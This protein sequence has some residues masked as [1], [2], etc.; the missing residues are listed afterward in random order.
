MF[1]VL[2]NSYKRIISLIG[3][4]L[5]SV[6]SFAANGKGLPDMGAPTRGQDKS[7][8]GTIQNYSYDYLVF[9]GLTLGAVAFLWVSMSVFSTYIEVQKGKKTWG[10]LGTTATVGIII[11]VFMIYL[12]TKANDIL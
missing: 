10:D 9:G 5:I 3:F 12:I 2:Q 4:M 8:L 1:K 11:L 7:I 6:N